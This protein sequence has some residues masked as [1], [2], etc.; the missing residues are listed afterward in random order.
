MGLL[1]ALGLW[2]LTTDP[3]PVRTAPPWDRTAREF[4]ARWFWEELG[5]SGEL[6]CVRT[7]LGITLGK[8]RWSYDGH[9]PVPVLPADLLAPDTP[10]GTPAALGATVSP[11]TSALRLVLPKPHA[12]RRGREFQAWLAANRP[13]LHNP[14]A[15]CGPTPAT[16]GSPDE[17][18]LTYV[19]CETR[20]PFHPL[21][22][23][24]AGEGIAP[25]MTRTGTGLLSVQPR[26]RS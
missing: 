14:S 15:R 8:E 1:V 23:Q 10:Q 7:D 3:E 18:K 12:R 19:V 13:P 5:A 6:V 24:G 9:R 11:E 20:G 17:P 2:R 21:W 4:R 22:R 26:R 25:T 16:R